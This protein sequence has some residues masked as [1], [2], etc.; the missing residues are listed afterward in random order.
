M[1]DSGSRAAREGR[2]GKG[3][4]FFLLGAFTFLVQRRLRV[5]FRVRFRVRVRA[6]AGVRFPLEAFDQGDFVALVVVAE[7][8]DQAAGEHDAK[9]P[10]AD[11]QLVADVEVA[12]RV[13]LRGGVGQ[14]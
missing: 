9:A 2:K 8:V 3:A 7:L 4:V 1:R 12:D 6:G 11:A 14:L 13:F 5:R 10:F